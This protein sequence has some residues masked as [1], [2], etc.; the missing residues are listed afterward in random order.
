MLSSKIYDQ[1][2][3]VWSVG[4]ILAE[5]LTNKV[6]FKADNYIEQVKTIIKI[7]GCQ[8]EQEIDFISNEGA[9]K[10]INSINKGVGIEFEE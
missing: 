9:I 7:L 1:K 10:F 4:C 2:I 3:D 6:M 5:L 8:Q